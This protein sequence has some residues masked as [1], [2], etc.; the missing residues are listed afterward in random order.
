MGKKTIVSL[1]LCISI[2]ASS[3][4]ADDASVPGTIT[5]EAVKKGIKVSFKLKRSCSGV[6]VYRY[7]GDKLNDEDKQLVYE[8]TSKKSNYSF[9]DE[10]VNAGEKYTYQISVNKEF[11]E[12]V[13]A[14]GGKG[15]VG[16]KIIPCETGLQI[17]LSNFDLGEALWRLYRH[18]VDD[19]ERNKTTF[20][21]GFIKE[22]FFI[23]EFVDANQ[24]Y[25]Y[26]LKVFVKGNLKND[27]YDHVFVPF[28]ALRM[29]APADGKYGDLT[30]INKP[31]AIYDESSKKVTFTTIPEVGA[32][33]KSFDIGRTIIHFI[34]D[35]GETCGSIFKGADSFVV[36]KPTLHETYRITGVDIG[37]DPVHSL[38]DS[39]RLTVFTYRYNLEDV[40]SEMPEIVK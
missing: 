39:S 18:R 15:E 7:V 28:C 4:Y 22:H 38:K 29:K 3:L 9:I 34:N 27:S 8:N 21:I 11:S 13:T 14:I 30:I 36:D 37:I 24:E 12:A 10:Y 17:K 33:S 20:W 35:K 16:I 31:T 1:F 6:N 32:G 5:A 25:V 19:D 23:D 26:N 2:F 40:F